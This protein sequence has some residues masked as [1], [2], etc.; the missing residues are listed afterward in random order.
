MRVLA[1]LGLF[2]SAAVSAQSHPG[3]IG[4][5]PEPGRF[6]VYG[7]LLGAGPIASA[8]IEATVL[9]PLYVRVGL[10]VGAPATLSAG[11]GVTIGQHRVRPDFAITGVV[12]FDG[13]GP[14]IMPFAGIRVIS[15][16]GSNFRIGVSAWLVPESRGIIF[17]WPSI[18]FGGRL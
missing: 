17:P 15:D 14:V 12:F 4:A 18:G 13:L 8:H 6:A 9:S 7:E 1:L 10:G 3:D 2:L 16:S 11:A 5:Q